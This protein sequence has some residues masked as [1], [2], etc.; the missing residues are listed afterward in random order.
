MP[1]KASSGYD[2]IS[3]KLLKLL[4]DEIS[5]P[6]CDLFNASLEQGVFPS[7]MKL[8]EVIPLHKGKSHDAPENYRPI[9]LLVTILKVLEKLV[10]KRV[11]GFLDSNGSLCNSQY[12]FLSKHSTDNAVTELLGE[13]LKNLE[14]KK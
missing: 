1:N 3:N 12:G 10:Y 14:N 8:S 9:S 5:E 13:I 4:K 2:N 6:L 7:N 11:Y